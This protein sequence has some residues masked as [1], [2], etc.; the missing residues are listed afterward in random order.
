MRPFF[1]YGYNS[2][3]KSLY[4]IVKELDKGKNINLQ[5]CGKLVR[6]FLSIDY[7]CKVIFKL[8]K[9]NKDI[10]IL[11]V[12]SGKKISVKNFIKKILENKRKLIN[13]NMNG[14]NPNFFE[15]NYFWGDTKK[16]KKILSSN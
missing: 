16:L 2:K 13:I 14:K 3:R 11:N 7:L 15:P 12:C 10:G 5:V 9:L 4:S 1:V 6:D 8:I